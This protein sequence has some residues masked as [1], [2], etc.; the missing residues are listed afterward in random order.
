MTRRTPATGP[1]DPRRSGGCCGKMSDR[2][3][4][5]PRPS[6]GCQGWGGFGYPPQPWPPLFWSYGRLLAVLACLP[7]PV[8]APRSRKTRGAR[9][10]ATLARVPAAT[11]GPPAA[12][13][14]GQAAPHEAL[15]VSAFITA[16]CLSRR[17]GCS[18]CLVR[19]AR[20]GLTPHPNPYMCNDPRE[21]DTLL[22]TLSTDKARLFIYRAGREGVRYWYDVE[23]LDDTYEWKPIFYMDDKSIQTFIDLFTK[24]RQVVESM[25]DTSLDDDE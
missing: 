1:P 11:T 12:R 20:D 9:A 18:A 25:E 16:S 4:C 19:L 2:C 23:V 6:L 21:S 24:A 15:F 13:R 10:A 3:K 8:V 7:E 5:F 14:G 22:D 17:T